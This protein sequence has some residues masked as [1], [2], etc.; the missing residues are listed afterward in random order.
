MKRL[1]ATSLVLI[2]LLGT[3]AFTVS[4]FALELDNKNKLSN[5]CYVVG[6]DTTQCTEKKWKK[7]EERCIKDDPNSRLKVRCE[8][9]G[10]DECTATYCN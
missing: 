10:W 9:G 5:A 4:V 6:D 2:T 3:L 8:S 7:N 1:F